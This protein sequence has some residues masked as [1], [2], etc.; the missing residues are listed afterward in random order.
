VQ[1]F[2]TIYQENIHLVYHF[3]YGKVGN[4]EEAEDLT[5][6]TFIKAARYLDQERNPA[7]IQKWLLQIARTTI[8]DYWRAYYRISS[9]SL[10]E[11]LYA[12]W[13]GPADEATGSQDLVT[14]EHLCAVERVQQILDALP[15]NYCEVLTCR[16]LLNLS[17]KE[18][19][20]RLG[21]TEANV[22]VLQFRALKRAAELDPLVARTSC[23]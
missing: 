2:Q 13:E 12:G 1:D 20:Q 6:Q 10:E 9:S 7:R 22:K 18:T 19:A 4:R 3:I 21:L 23:K 8:A 17:I 16:F 15:Q 14:A 11:L 5:S